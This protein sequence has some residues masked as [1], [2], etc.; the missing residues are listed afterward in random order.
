MN[1]VPDPAPPGAPRCGSCK[2]ALDTSGAPQAVDDRSFAE[3]IRAA[4]VP[5][6]VDFWAPWCGPCR[7]AAP[8]LD[9]LARAR[10]GELLVLKLDT[11]ESPVTA[12]RFSVTSIPSFFV[13]RDGQVVARQAGLPP[14]GAFELW[15]D[16][17]LGGRPV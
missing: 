12:S 1:R 5:V 8:M 4:P 3:A 13:F 15:L 6:V 2:R 9:A 16:Q 11:D 7:M 10:A 14:R 17:A